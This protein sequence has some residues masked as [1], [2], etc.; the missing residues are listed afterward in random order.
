MKSLITTMFR[1]KY[2]PKVTPSFDQSRSRMD[3]WLFPLV[4]LLCGV[5]SP[6]S[7]KGQ[8][9]AIS[10]NFP[11]ISTN[12]LTRINSHILKSRKFLQFVRDKV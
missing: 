2:L 12:V 5:G 10:H 9:R 4:C 6:N 7:K 8:I 3:L 1:N 11:A